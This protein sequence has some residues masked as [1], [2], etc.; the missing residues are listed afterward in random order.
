MNEIKCPHCGEA[1]KIDEAGYADIVKQIKDDQYEKD[2]HERLKLIEDQQKA[3]IELEK[4]KSERKLAEELVKKDQAISEL[5]A[6]IDQAET[7]KKLELQQSVAQIEKERDA[8]KAENKQLEM[9]KELETQSIKEK[10]EIQIKDRDDSIER[11]KEYKAQLST[12][13]LGET[14][15]LH[16][17]NS[18]EKIRATAFPNAQF[19][20]D[21]DASSGSKGD[22]IFREFDQEG[23]EI[24]SIMFEMKNQD[25]ATAT[26]KKNTDFLKELDKDRNEKNCEYAI[27]VSMLEEDS[28]LYNDGIVDVS[29]RYPKM[30]VVRPQFFIPIISLLRNAALNS[31]KYKQELAQVRAQ[32][33]DIENFEA[34]LEDFKAGFGKNYDLASRKFHEAIKEIDE[35]I[36]RLNKVK[37]ALLSSENNLR[38]ANRKAQDVT[39]K[40]LTKDNPTMADK[41]K[42]LEGK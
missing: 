3:Q 16:C 26:K 24:V 18:F 34:E 30:F 25:E 9:Q 33:I 38:I 20:K 7:Q 12:K 15:E 23:N 31:L 4:E 32:N 40:K 14:L 41:F 11:L 22:Y 29:H 35:S 8:L 21:N 39:I 1:F 17:E 28:E 19:G 5:K 2:L 27:L 6:M 13:M 37:D 36:K 10:Y 42:E